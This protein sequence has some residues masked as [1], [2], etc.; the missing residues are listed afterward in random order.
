MTRNIRK[1][2]SIICAVALLLS[3]SVVSL[4]G[5]SSAAIPAGDEVVAKWEKVKEYNFDN[6]SGIA[7]KRFIDHTSFAN[8]ALWVA[9]S[10]GGGGVWFAEDPACATVIDHGS[11]NSD[12]K[13]TAYTNM[14]KLEPNTTY[15][16]TY[17]YK[18]L[19]G[20]NTLALG[21]LSP[22]TLQA[23]LLL[24]SVRP[25]AVPL[26]FRIHPVS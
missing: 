22:P 16:V 7:Y 2:V 18:Y 13:A 23:L 11:A 4:T 20:S 5:S 8:G 6:S 3:L 1:I 15:K 26:L 24:V 10:G 12:Q 21:L 17:K 9:N 25:V 19:A 14:L